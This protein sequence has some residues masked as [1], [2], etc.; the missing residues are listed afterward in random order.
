MQVR[1]GG[2]G[3]WGG[4]LCVG[5]RGG[6]RGTCVCGGGAGCMWGGRGGGTGAHVPVWGAGMA[7]AAVQARMP[8]KDRWGSEEGPEGRGRLNNG[9]DLRGQG[10]Q[11]APH[12]PI[13]SWAPGPP[14]THRPSPLQNYLESGPLRPPSPPLPPAELPGPCVQPAAG[15][16]G[17]VPRLPGCGQ[18]GHAEGRGLHLQRPRHEC[19]GEGEGGG[20]EERDRGVL[21]MSNTHLG[22]QGACLWRGS[23]KRGSIFSIVCTL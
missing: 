22:R 7:G 3:G 9:L 11:P 18:G 4:R 17:S 6:D 8:S 12:L 15:Y 10:K 13:F 21:G 14:H 2:G 23:V 16:R 20:R 19:L 1:A 5:G